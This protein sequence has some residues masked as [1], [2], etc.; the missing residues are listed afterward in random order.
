MWK[1]TLGYSS[2]KLHCYLKFHLVARLQT[3]TLYVWY[4]I[5]HFWVYTFKCKWFAN[6]ST[7]SKVLF[8]LAIV[9]SLDL[10]SLSRLKIQTSQKAQ[11]FLNLK[12]H[13]QMQTSSPSPSHMKC[14]AQKFLVA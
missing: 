10:T 5:G 11:I 3:H 12:L 8:S 14:K 13:I 7:F 6:L 1:L 4:A 2:Y 9:Q